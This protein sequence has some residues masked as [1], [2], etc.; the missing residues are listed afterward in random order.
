[1][2]W[3]VREAESTWRGRMARFRGGTLTVVEFC[4]R[5]GVSVPSFYQWRKRLEPATEP[6]LLGEN[7]P[8]GQAS[9]LFVPVKVSSTPMA[10]IEFPSGVRVRVPATNVDAI[11]A[12]ILA[13][14]DPYREVPSC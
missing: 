8:A 4:R 13:G 11:R 9:S 10:E 2:G 6:R 1:M 7:S 12:A 3:N 14:G 5:E